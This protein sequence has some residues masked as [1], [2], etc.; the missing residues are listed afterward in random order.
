MSCHKINWS[1]VWDA[2]SAIATTAAVIVALWQT[3]YANKKK[4]KLSFTDKLTIVP[5]TPPGMVSR[6]K[7]NQFIG[8][9]FANIGNRKIV[10]RE[11]WIELP[12]DF[13]ADIQPD[14]PPNGT[15][16]FPLAV[17]IEESVVL[18]LSKST[19]ISYLER[20]KRLARNK[21]IT[22]CVEDSTGIIYKCSTSKT[23]QQYL[24]NEKK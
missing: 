6:V 3:R 9:N 12:D 4:A 22:F 8:V 16:Y 2:T 14:N 1:I 20:E 13:R 10:I 5:A 17:D 21:K 7:K 19:F 18:P 23:V 24:N 15:N 11:F